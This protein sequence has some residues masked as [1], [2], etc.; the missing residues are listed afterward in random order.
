LI[1]RRL[2]K[3]LK[4]LS[5]F[6]DFNDSLAAAL[7]GARLLWQDQVDASRIGDVKVGA[8]FAFKSLDLEQLSVSYMVNAEDFFQACTSSTWTWQRLQ[9]LALTSQSLQPVGSRQEIDTLLYQAGV[10][11]LRMPKL[12]ILVLWN[13]TK[14]NACAFIYH[15]GGASA[16]VTWRSTWDLELS[17]RV[18]EVWE[19]VALENRS[20]PLRIGKQRVEDVIRSHGD[21]IYHLGLPCRVVAPVSLWQIRREGP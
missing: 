13:G 10:V 11:A 19:R 5:I 14:G 17:P 2:P 8:A 4:K 18:V 9:S 12:H 7:G 20:Y 21:A 1:Q 15:T 3:T 16:H 6:E